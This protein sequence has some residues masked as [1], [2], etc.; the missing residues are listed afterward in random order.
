MRVQKIIPCVVIA[1]LLLP[2]IAYAGVMADTFSAGGA[3]FAI[4]Q[5][6]IIAAFGALAVL[7]TNALGKAQVSAMIKIVTVFS[8]LAIVIGVVVSAIGAVA[9]AFGV[10]L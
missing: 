8:C 6:L 2:R 1:L 4:V 10:P 5:L 7:I 3:G 9:K